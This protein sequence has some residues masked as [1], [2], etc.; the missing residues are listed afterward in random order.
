MGMSLDALDS[1]HPIE[2][3][4]NHPSEVDE[5]FDHISY[6]K[7]SS[8]IRM[9]HSWIGDAA[10]RKGMAAYLNKHAYSNTLTE[11]LWAA[12]EAASGMPVGTVMSSWTSQMGFPL[13]KVELV[14]GTETKLKISQQKFSANGPAKQSDQIWQIPIEICSADS[15]T[16]AIKKLV[17]TEKE[18]IVELDGPSAWFK[19]NCGTVGFYRVQYDAKMAAALK[20]NALV[21][22][23]RLQ[24]QSD[25]FAL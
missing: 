12:L 14:E 2:V 4:V 8:T 9:L 24:L 23:D 20:V 17:L 15:P 11:D 3:P 18:Q 7:G 6:C 10:F 5:I 25:T 13:V 1:S 22:R 21:T 19:L 16:K